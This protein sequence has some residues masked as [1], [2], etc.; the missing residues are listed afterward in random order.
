MAYVRPCREGRWAR[1]VWSVLCGSPDA[2]GEAGVDTRPL[3]PV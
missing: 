2:S 1:E 3:N